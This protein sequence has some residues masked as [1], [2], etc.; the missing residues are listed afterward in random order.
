MNPCVLIPIYDH[1]DPIRG[2]VESLVPHGLPCLIVD[3]GSDAATRS[4]LSELEA[5]FD[6]VSVRRRE[7][8]GGRGAA[9]KTGYRWA[10][11][12]GFSHVV[13]VDADGQ[14]LAR[15]VPKFVQAMTTT[16]LEL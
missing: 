15:D 4:V 9:L 8:N 14:H 1:K 13:Q 2:V 3:D 7:R 6:L 10:A 11:E 16:Y 5:E 12:R